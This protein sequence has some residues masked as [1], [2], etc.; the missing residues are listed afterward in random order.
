MDDSD[1]LS[2]LRHELRKRLG[3]ERYELWLGP[4]TELALADGA[5]RVRC[6]SPAEAQWL[7]RELDAT[8]A[9]VRHAI[10]GDAP[11]DRV[12][13]GRARDGNGRLRSH[14]DQLRR[15]RHGEAGAE[16]QSMRSRDARASRCRVS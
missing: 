12:R 5:L 13:A 16:S 7:R 10:F 15:R 3:D 4:Q 11:D 1:R 6:A 8:L 14:D 9:S 2:A